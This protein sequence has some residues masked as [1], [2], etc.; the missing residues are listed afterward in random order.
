MLML[1]IK[2]AYPK[3]TAG[4]GGT[5]YGISIKEDKETPGSFFRH[6]ARPTVIHP[7]LLHCFCIQYN[8]IF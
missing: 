8:T 4:K 3:I 2:K 6:A 1:T 7:S 5:T